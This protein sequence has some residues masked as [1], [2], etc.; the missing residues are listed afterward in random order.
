[1]A[2]WLEPPVQSKPSFQE[3][4]LMRGGVVENMAPLGTLPRAAMHKRSQPAGDETP[5][6]SVK[7][8]VLK[9]T[10]KAAPTEDGDVH[11]AAAGR[12]N[13]VEVEVADGLADA[14]ETT[15]T[16]TSPTRPL[17]PVTGLDDSEDDDYRPNNIKAKARRTSAN[18]GLAKRPPGR[19]RK[20]TTARAKSPAAA[21]AP[22]PPP[23]AMAHSDS[24]TSPAPS[25]V[26]APVN[27]VAP[28]SLQDKEPDNKPL[29][30]LAVEY[31]VEEALQHHRYPTA[32][33]LRL[34][35][36]DN[37]KDNRFVAMIEDIYLQRADVDTQREFSRLVREKKKE[38][39]RDNTACDYFVPPSPGNSRSTPNKPK[40]A[41]Y[42]A[43]LTMD[44]SAAK[45]PSKPPPKAPT[46][47][48]VKLSK[49]TSEDGD[50]H[51]SKKAR[52]EA[53]SAPVS[54]GPGLANGGRGR[55]KGING[56]ASAKH[57]P[58]K[59]SPSKHSP[60]K[61]SSSKHSPTKSL[62]KSPS[63]GRRGRS[64]SVSSDSSLSEVPDDEPE[65]YDEFKKMLDDEISRPST[66]EPNHAPKSG[67]VDQPISSPQQK[68]T[69]KKTPRP[70]AA[71]PIASGTQS[72]AHPHDSDMSAAAVITN[73]TSQ[74][75][76]PFTHANTPLR[77][78]SKYAEALNQDPLIQR[79]LQA[80]AGTAGLTRVESFASFTREPLAAD[81]IEEALPVLP[82]I[83]EPTRSLRTPVALTGRAARAA[84][85][86]HEDAESSPVATEIEPPSTRSSRA[87]TPSGNLRSTKKPKTSGLRVKNS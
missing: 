58:S 70:G 82:P 8:I 13:V 10:P 53:S 48:P 50:G 85:R 79:K 6:P 69:S 22:P 71:S 83:A 34:L 30:D 57:S 15:V 9:K 51:V 75:R 21:A 5:A 72:S 19:P 42:G 33:A 14:A 84:K 77:F 44:F 87:A 4:G 24:P 32:W 3:A 59:H 46:L 76:P 55:P 56:S 23:L 36:D 11:Q 61:H 45:T 35:Y 25:P 66:A 73:G 67:D 74:Q 65:D 37:S 1:M 26:P 52:L 18:N 60:S 27:F 81:S 49:H 38:G 86:N 17:F 80:K 40:P 41:P 31:A 28:P 16:T 7:R 63:K 12:G 29:A 39:K 20:N 2:R 68:P 62:T 78:A 43:M 47:S 54:M 64:G